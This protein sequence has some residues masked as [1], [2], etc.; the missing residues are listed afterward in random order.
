MDVNKLRLTNH[1]YQRIKERFNLNCD[2]EGALNYC[3]GRLKNAE[4]IGIIVS[5]E[6]EETVLYAIGREAY[7]LSLDETTIKTVTKNVK[8]T[9]EPIKE[10]IKE[11]HMKELRKLERKEKS[12]HKYLEL[13]MLEANIELSQLKYRLH[14]TRSQAVKMACQAR[15]NALEITLQELQDEI[16]NIKKEKTRIA[17]SMVA[18]V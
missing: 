8:I 4:R 15:I 11:M 1:A 13:L 3:K 18:V 16:N 17:R 7:Y 6:G 12:K 10:K 14:K 5:K 9:Y 2:K